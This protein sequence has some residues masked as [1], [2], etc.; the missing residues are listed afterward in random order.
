MAVCNVHILAGAWFGI[1]SREQKS[2]V[3]GSGVDVGESNDND[4]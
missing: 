1:R 3:Q 2:G 4:E